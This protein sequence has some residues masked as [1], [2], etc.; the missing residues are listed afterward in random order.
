MARSFPP[1]NAR[2]PASNIIPSS[3]IIAT[4]IN[5]LP[6]YR[7]IQQGR[8]LEMAWKSEHAREGQVEAFATH[9]RSFSSAQSRDI[10]IDSCYDLRSIASFDEHD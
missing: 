1:A 9:G 2:R 8:E 10:T 4:F 3:E 7:S 5:D 6:V